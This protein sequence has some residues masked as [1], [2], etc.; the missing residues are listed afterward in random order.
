MIFFSS[1]GYGLD[2]AVYQVFLDELL[3][4]SVDCAFALFGK[5]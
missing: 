3:L 4:L 2:T 1:R 5:G